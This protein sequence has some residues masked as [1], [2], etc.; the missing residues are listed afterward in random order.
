MEVSMK[1]R[2]SILII[3][4]I[5][6][7]LACNIPMET[8]NSGTEQTQ[9]A[10]GIQ[11]TLLAVA[12]TEAATGG[13]IAEQPEEPPAAPPAEPAAPAAPAEPAQ[14]AEQP[15]YT[16]YPTYTVPPAPPADPPTQAPPPTQPPQDMGERIR[17]ARILLYDN[18]YGSYDIYG[19]A[20]TSYIADAVDG[21][22]LGGNTTNVR[23]AMGNFMTE[24]NSGTQWDLII[25]GA[26][27]RSNI[28]GEFW[29]VIGDHMRNDVAVVSEI[30]YLDQIAIGRIT[31]VLNMCG[32][33]YTAD[34]QRDANANLNNYLIY[35][36]EPQS[37]LFSDPNS[38]GMLIPTSNYA[39][40]GDVGDRVK[41]TDGSKATLMAGVLPNERQTGGLIAE[42]MEGRVIFQTFDTHDYKYNDMIALW[43]NYVTYTLTNHFKAIDQ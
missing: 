24:L 35:I 40:V 39:W 27:S 26:E 17:G 3:I 28:R 6:M 34:W 16:P 33:D 41:I 36:L 18:T 2:L 23:D 37:P 9:V 30:W 21:M 19:R 5:L 32:I 31:P 13:Q 14:P 7:T 20:M 25:V 42:C 22:G 15:T 11:A 8:S 38:V 1:Q 29:D 12:Q 43:Q 10:L 4:F